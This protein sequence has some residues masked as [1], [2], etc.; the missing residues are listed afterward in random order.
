MERNPITRHDWDQNRVLL[1]APAFCP[2]EV[3]GSEFAIPLTEHNTST[4]E[5][6]DYGVLYLKL[7]IYSLCRS[8]VPSSIKSDLIDLGD[9]FARGA[10][11][12]PS[13]VTY[14]H[15]GSALLAITNRH[16]TQYWQH[17]RLRPVVVPIS[18]VLCLQ[19]RSDLE[20]A[21]MM[22]RA[23]QP[24]GMFAPAYAQLLTRHQSTRS[25]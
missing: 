25:L 11:S 5:V 7:Y 10:V 23:S 8:D 12:T 21:I 18:C 2:T 22:A 20:L 19:F 1:D 9:R 6:R 24:R 15:K 4:N 14:K 17:C 13:Q 16:I 3:D